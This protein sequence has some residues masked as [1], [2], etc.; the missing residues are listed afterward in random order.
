MKRF[1]SLLLI[2]V[3]FL[4]PL[5]MDGC[6]KRH[7]IHLD[8]QMVAKERE[9]VAAEKAAAREALI[10]EL[11]ARNLQSKTPSDNLW[12]GFRGSYP[13]HSQVLALSNPAPQDQTRTL[14]ISEPPPS[15]GLGDLLI[16]TRDIL[17][18]HTVRQQPIGHDGWT[19]DVVL[20][21][22]GSEDKIAS[23]VSAL[24][25]ILFATSYKS[26]VV[27]LPV[28]TQRGDVSGL[29]LKVTAAEIKNW[30]VEQGETFLPAEGGPAISLS[31]LFARSDS[32]VYFTRN[33]G[34][35]TWWI[36]KGKDIQTCRVEIREFALDSDLIIGALSN[37]SGILI[38]G[39]ERVIPVELLPPLRAETISLLA[40]VQK[41]QTGQL[42][43]SYERR[44]LFAGRIERN[45]DWA[46]ILLS[47]ELVDTEYGSL[48][49]ITDQILKGWSNGGDTQYENFH[50][51]KPS[52]WPFQNP[53]LMQRLDTDEL[54]YNWN[55]K[56]VGYAVK[57][58]DY[59]VFALHRSG[60]LPVSYI[61]EGAS[62]GRSETVAGAEDKAYD[63]FA[64]LS[65]PN[66]VR[67]VQYDS[68]Y[69]IFSVFD[70]AKPSITVA[71]RSEPDTVLERLTKEMAD[72]VKNASPEEK[73][74]LTQRLIPVVTQ[75]L[76][77][78]PQ[79][80]LRKG[81]R[82]A[83]DHPEK[84]EARSRPL[85]DLSAL[86]LRDDS[87]DQRWIKDI[88]LSELAGMKKLPSRYADEIARDVNGWIHTPVVVVSNNVNGNK[89]GV[90]IGGHNLYAKV[91]N[92]TVSEDAA[93]GRPVVAADGTIMVNPKDAGRVSELVRTAGLAE[94]E[95][96]EAVSSQLQN[97]LKS[98]SEVSPRPR[99]LALNLSSDSLSRNLG[100]PRTIT[101]GERV[102]LP[103]WGRFRQQ[104]ALS[105]AEIAAVR[106][107][108]AITADAIVISR[109]SDG[110]IRVFVDES[111]GMIQAHTIEDASDIVT[112]L[113]RK[114]RSDGSLKLD[115]RGFNSEEGAAF[116]KTCE[117]RAA[118][119]NIPR[120]ISALVSDGSL[121]EIR[122][123]RFEFSKAN[124]SDVGIENLPSGEQRSTILVD[125]P[126][127]DASEIV[128]KTKIELIF[129]KQTPREI[130]SAL[131]QMVKDAISKVIAQL[132]DTLDM[133]SFNR[134]VNLEIKR[135]SR[136]TGVDIKLIRQ[137]FNAE[138]R[139]L[140]F[141]RKDP[142]SE[143][144]SSE[145]STGWSD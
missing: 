86:G 80:E 64:N 51:P 48:L 93:V 78:F 46:P 92:F 132:G 66:L 63:Y 100:L 144:L 28:A 62:A 145:Y 94:G 61:P 135:I 47:P 67:V 65:D 44:H 95:T 69:H 99:S 37:A 115:L 20:A 35:V 87:E 136:E 16:P 74:A 71:S 104:R 31:D 121:E 96:T 4:F 142:F 75:Q 18:N 102:Q 140:H 68:L 126:A 38:F 23:A 57:M 6:T 58:G 117:I 73:A 39:R 90:E 56:G 77:D 141:V 105:E 14:I 120:E 125:V 85:I 55:T 29:D 8:K 114:T 53:S 45:K 107:S 32:S 131:T 60:A 123:R 81:I 15:L 138:R 112:Q 30:T 3:F 5:L 13:Y 91:T 40:A 59:N 113:L 33:P 50:Y 42:E 41:G 22:K 27:P 88:A 70:I 79:D 143:Y 84:E 98:V 109:D 124:I 36:P 9:R 111:N 133:L 134:A 83:L 26:Y 54:T 137:Q 97:V 127:K 17:L 2:L 89:L 116:V 108:R 21:V 101:A 72:E 25:Q 130:I 43:Q 10:R 82:A 128:G 129:E 106:A 12:R 49:N 24:N 118:D 11:T 76:G 139:D 34:L 122:L 119:E 52:T 19:R 110:A 103:G 1:H 7:S